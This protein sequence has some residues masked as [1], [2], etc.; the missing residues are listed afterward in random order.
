[1]TEE[2]IIKKAK[3]AEEEN[4]VGYDYVE[5]A[6]IDGYIKGVEENG[7]VW[8][9]LRINPK[10]LPKENTF[11][12]SNIGTI[13]FYKIGCWYDAISVNDFYSTNEVTAW[14]EIPKFEVE[15]WKL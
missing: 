9:D 1:M 6:Y 4:C 13:V 10:D 14:C 15:E 7:T 8:H 12:I 5:E 3:K 2:Q 11:V